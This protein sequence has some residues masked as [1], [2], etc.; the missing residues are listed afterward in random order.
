M[1]H[2]DQARLDS[3]SDRHIF[4]RYPESEILGGETAFSHFKVLMSN[5]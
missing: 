3:G 1:E 2:R 5:V 4:S